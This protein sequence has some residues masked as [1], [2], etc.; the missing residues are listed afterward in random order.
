MARKGSWK[1]ELDRKYNLLMNT[2]S[3]ELMDRANNVI[4]KAIEE[5]DSIKKYHKR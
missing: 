4:L 2:G 1:N 5:L 3:I